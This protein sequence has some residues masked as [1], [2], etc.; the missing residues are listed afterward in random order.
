M[1][2]KLTM[3]HMA[4]AYLLN[5][6][7]HYNQ[8]D[9]ARLMK[10]SQGTISNMIREFKYQRQIHDLEKELDE[11]RQLLADRSL[12]PD[13]RNFSLSGERPAIDSEL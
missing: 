3:Q 12:L 6:E 7:L 2:R 11:A 5:E 10:V 8:S 13:S 9:I 1:S 4:V